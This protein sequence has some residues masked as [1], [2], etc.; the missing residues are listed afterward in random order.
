MKKIFILPLVIF[1]LILFRHAH[2]QELTPEQLFEKYN[3]A[4][5][6]ITSFDY[7]GN[8]SK[9][10]SGVILNDKGI[11]LTNYHVFA[12]NEKMEIKHR[13][14]TINYTAVVGVNIEKDI[15]ILKIDGG[16]YPNIDLAKREDL[17]V[18]QKVYA[19]GSPMGL[20]NTLSDGLLSGF[21]EIGKTIK[22]NY[23]QISAS[24]S[25]GSSGGPVFNSRGELIG[26]SN[27]SME[28]GQNLNFAIP[29][30][31]IMSVMQGDYLDQNKLESLN[32]FYKGYNAVEN[33]DYKEALTDYSKYIEKNPGDAKA[34]NYRG[35]AYIEMKEYKK[36]I[37]DFT[38]AVQIDAK[39]VVAYNNRAEANYKLEEYGKAEQ[40]FS[41]SI[42]I[43]PD[44]I[45]AYYGRGLSYSKDEIHDKA[46][47]DFSKVIEL[48]PT[49]VYSYVNR[50]FS[51][52]A[53]EEY[54]Y[55]I[56]DWEKSIRLD[57]DL[58]KSLRPFINYAN[59]KDELR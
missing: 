34:Y 30:D 56:R 27:M 46:L 40:D 35:L 50:G 41:K 2:A 8:K 10:G 22:K 45:S 29:I 58:E 6:V 43:E 32:Y 52:Y 42:Q 5:V 7:D 17:K 49:F 48:D 4:V 12:G 39:F 36:S 25:P 37:P 33:G 20:E 54:E 14:N 11:I 44:N 38:K 19:I 24:I 55:A 3:D 15:L 13:D 59:L 1:L 47:K 28:E 51:Y 31:D 18:G 21:R 16:S 9:Q 23:I 26:I 53:L 57:P